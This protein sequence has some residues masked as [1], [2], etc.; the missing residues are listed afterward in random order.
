MKKAAL[1]ATAAIAIVFGACS[2]SKFDGYTRAENGLH[3]KFFNH[4]ESAPKVQLGDGIVI[5]YVI[6]KEK[7]DSLI[8][9]SKNVSQDGSGYVSFTMRKSS[10]TGSFEDGMMMMSMGDSAAFVVSADSFF[11]KTNGQNELP[12]GFKPGEYLKGVFKIKQIRTAKELEENQ[13]KQRE[14][15]EAMMKDMQE[16]EKP[17]L[18]K[19]LADNKI[20]VKP[21][22]SGLYFIET[23]KGSGAKP[24]DGDEVE[25]NYQGRLLDGTLFDTSLEELAKKENVYNPQRPYEPLKFVI[26]ARQVI[27]GWEEAIS[28]LSKGG[29]AKI[30]LPSNIA[31]GSSGSGPIPPYAPLVFEVELV[32][33]RQAPAAPAGH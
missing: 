3:Y 26:G 4:D 12:P 32:N 29:K 13:K 19:Y 23:K 2:D 16:K 8:V 31:Y 9:D 1:F 10:F 27:P 30:V 15:Q 22:A 24:K 25:V 21:T 17:V 20:T 7:N 6:S 18:D 14:E 11:L 33:F 5:S 28:M